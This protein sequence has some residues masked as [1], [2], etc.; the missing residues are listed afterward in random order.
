MRLYGAWAGNPGWFRAAN[1]GVRQ[2][3]GAA[4]V[5]MLFAKALRLLMVVLS[6]FSDDCFS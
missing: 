5:G 3:N 6:W 2:L 4:M 1:T